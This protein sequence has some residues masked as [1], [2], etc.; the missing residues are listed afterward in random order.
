[1]ADLVSQMRESRTARAMLLAFGTAYLILLPA[2]AAQAQSIPPAGQCLNDP[3]SCLPSP[4][5]VPE[6]DKCVADPASCLPTIPPV[7][8][9]VE[10]PASCL[11]AVPPVD[12]CV[13]DP[14]SCLPAVVP[15]VEEC[16][17]GL[18]GCVPE[19]EEVDRCLEDV[20]RC[21][22]PE[23]NENENGDDD[24]GGGAAPVEGNQPPRHS[25]HATGRTESPPDAA[26]SASGGST[27]PPS[28]GGTEIGTAAFSSNAGDLLERIERG[29]ADAAQ[30]FAFPLAVAALVGAFLLIQ[31][32]ID[33][34]DPKLAVAPI[35][36][37]DDVVTFY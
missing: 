12:E 18:Q 8:P 14:T 9:C 19:P 16:V 10:D 27:A 29:L 23:E 7:D 36:S 24:E 32:R 3:A 30:R 35:D 2:R 34:R 25:P 26:G 22:E 11:P 15:D 4:P 6:P 5:T 1:M 21:L 31:G 20:A 17:K 13:Q 33:S 28:E 37:P